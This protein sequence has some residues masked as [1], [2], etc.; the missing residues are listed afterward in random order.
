MAPTWLWWLL[1]S[2]VGSASCHIP[3]VVLARASTS[4][5]RTANQFS[6][7]RHHSE[8]S[9]GW[10]WRCQSELGPVFSHWKLM[11]D[12]REESLKGY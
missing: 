1:S 8:S 3:V 11:V 5:Q 7:V 4:P 9:P 12:L 10:V 2:P 6:M